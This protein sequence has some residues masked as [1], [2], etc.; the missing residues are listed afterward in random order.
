MY[1]ITVD[2]Y[3]KVEGK[4]SKREV[5]NVITNKRGVNG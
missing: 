3:T 2:G 1:L 4:T 5:L